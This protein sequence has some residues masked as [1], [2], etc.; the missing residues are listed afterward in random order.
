MKR[1]YFLLIMGVVLLSSCSQVKKADKLRLEHKFEEA[2]ALY[3]KAASK[4]DAYAMWRLGQCY[5]NGN[6]V[7]RDKKKAYE[8]IKKAAEKGCVEAKTDMACTQIYGWYNKK[9]EIKKGI[10]RLTELTSKTD[11]PYTQFQFALMYWNGIDGEIEQNRSKAKEILSNIKDKNSP[12]YNYLMGFVYCY[13]TDGTDMDEEKAVECWKK[14]FEEGYTPGA[15]HIAY[16][17]QQGGSQIMKDIEQAVEWYKKGIEANSA[18]CMYNLALVYLSEDTMTQKYHN[19]REAILLLKKAIKQKEGDAC[20]EMGYLYSTGQHVEKDDKEATKY[21]K[22]ADEYGSASGSL[23]L[24]VHYLT[25]R[26]IEEDVNEARKCY[27]RA[28]ERGNAEAALRLARMYEDNTFGKPNMDKCLEYLEKAVKLGSPRAY[29]LIARQYYYGWN[30]Y[31][32]DNFQAFV[33]FKK[34]ADAGYIDAYDYLIEMYEKGWGCDKN[35]AK[36]KEYKKK[37]ENP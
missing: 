32:E 25:G 8:W 30:D 37:L 28:V 23:N 9:K 14:S 34:A 35:P 12:Y 36:A 22:M 1:L 18:T 21:Y 16:L 11:N 26:G 5:D 6:G 7:E 33:Y 2:A 31:P 4:G 19:P 15:S 29:Y 24:G 13:G 10:Q 17:Y 3:Q 27:E 20:S